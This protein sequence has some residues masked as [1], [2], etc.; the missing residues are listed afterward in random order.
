MT[1]LTRISSKGQI[2]IPIKIRDQ[3]SMNEGSIIAMDT[4]KDLIIL[5][6][7]D[8]DLVNQFKNSLSDLKTGKIKRVA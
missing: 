6:K 1:E 3:L 7:V 8:V 2:V 4:T 5:K